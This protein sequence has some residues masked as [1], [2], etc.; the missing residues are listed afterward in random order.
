MDE[1]LPFAVFTVVVLVLMA[2]DLGVFHRRL[3]RLSLREATAWTVTWIALALSFNVG[4]YFWGGPSGDGGKVALEFFTGYVLEYSLSVDN[5]FV[6]VLIF[7]Y[8]AVPAEY[9]HK[10]LFWGVL[11]ALVM[12][13]VFI[14]AGVALIAHFDWVFYVFGSFLLVTG[15]M[16]ARHREEEVHPER[17]LFIRLCRRI[18]PVTKD[19]VGARFFVKQS[20]KLAIT[21][22][23]L[24]LVMVETTDLVFALDSIPAIF[25]VTQDPFIVY[26]SNV[27]AILG[28]RSLYFV[29]AGVIEKFRFLKFGL[30]AVLSFVGL[31]MLVA[32]VYHVPVQYS[33]LTIVLLLGASVAASIVHKRRTMVIEPAAAGRS[34]GRPVAIPRPAKEDE[35]IGGGALP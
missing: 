27:F 34:D 29:L 31:K 25:G 13:A 14:A 32:D 30:A 18:F 23:F 16:M 3:H 17:N 8:F 24:V 21:P 20:G 10:V 35:K 4:L 7:S 26:T 33:L 6:F 9:Q 1:T 19:Y 22:L 15:I 12:R 28:L 11:G 5:I 2:L